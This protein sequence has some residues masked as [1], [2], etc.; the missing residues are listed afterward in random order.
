[1]PYEKFTHFL[2]PR[3]NAWICWN[4][5]FGSYGRD[6]TRF[7]EIRHYST[8][9]KKNAIDGFP[10]W[11]SPYLTF[12]FIL[13]VLGMMKKIE[14]KAHPRYVKFGVIQHANLP[15]AFLFA[16]ALNVFTMKHGNSEKYSKYL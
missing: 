2:N 8:S 11:M 9:E 16:D 13:S 6:K 7:E 10:F 4:Y 1:M 15:I 12:T 5:D 14:M 3:K